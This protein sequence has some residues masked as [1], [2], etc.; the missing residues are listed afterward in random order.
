VKAIVLSPGPSLASYV[1]READMILGVNRAATAFAVDCWVCGDTPLVEQIADKIIGAPTLVTYAVTRDTLRDHGFSWRGELE[2]WT[3]IAE[4]N[5]LHTSVV[6]WPWCSFC[7]AIV[8][9]AHKGATEIECFGC[10]WSG[11]NDWDGTA[12]GKNRSDDRWRE[13]RAIFNALVEVL[14]SRG[15]SVSRSIPVEAQSQIA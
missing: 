11:R 12:A 6:N 14:R 2:A 1:P 4:S 9:A 13:E 8:Y 5:W 7:A 3:S 10:D 15:C